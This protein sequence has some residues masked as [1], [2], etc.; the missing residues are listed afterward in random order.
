MT[1]FA[2]ALLILLA[3]MAAL[4]AAPAHDSRAP[5]E[6]KADHFL[7]DNDAHTGTWWGNV[8][9]KQ[10][11]LMMHA[12][13]VRGHIKGNSADKIYADGHV[14]V[15]SPKSG[16][17]TGDKGVYDVVRRTITLEGHVVLKKQKDVMRGSTLAVNLATGKAELDAKKSPGGRVQAIFTP[18]SAGK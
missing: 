3:P 18:A 6:I 2:I 9:V 8:V 13:K 14:V 4:A 10:G 1:K 16:T 7:A 12:D 17:A 15:D 11:D 5:I